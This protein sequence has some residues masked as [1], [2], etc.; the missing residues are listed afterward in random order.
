[1]VG[2]WVP[3]HVF[4]L[5]ASELSRTIWGTV[6]PIDRSFFGIRFSALALF[7]NFQ[8]SLGFHLRQSPLD[9]LAAEQRDALRC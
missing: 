4:W 9:I 3:E 6:E 2:R 5:G 7:P 8:S 1:M